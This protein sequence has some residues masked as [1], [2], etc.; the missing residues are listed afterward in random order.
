M[1]IHYLE[2]Y[3]TRSAGAPIPADLTNRRFPTH[4]I[5]STEPQGLPPSDGPSPWLIVAGVA[6]AAAVGFIIVRN[7]KKKRRR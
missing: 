4:E 1:T 3:R 6:A 7:S 5:T 2:N